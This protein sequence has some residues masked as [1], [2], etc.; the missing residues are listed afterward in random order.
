MLLLLDSLVIEAI[1]A[2]RQ[3]GHLIFPSSKGE[4]ANG[5]YQETFE[6]KRPGCIAYV[7]VMPD[8]PANGIEI[9]GTAISLDCPTRRWLHQI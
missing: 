9:G 1:S 7:Q 4:L 5:K 6:C 2:S 3:R 8:P